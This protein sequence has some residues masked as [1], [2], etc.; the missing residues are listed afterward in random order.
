MLR[1]IDIELITENADGHVRARNTG[2]L[3]SA[4]ETLVTLRVVV[5]QADLQLD[6]LEEVALLLL[7]AV[8]EEFLYIRTHTSDRDFRHVGCR[9][10]NRLVMRLL[11]RLCVEL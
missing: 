4:R 6:R 9:S 1:T 3:D 7:I 5:L 2:K 11:V 10:S 8:F